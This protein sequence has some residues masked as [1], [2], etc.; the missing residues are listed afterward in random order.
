MV[1][2]FINTP[3]PMMKVRVITF[4]DSYERTLKHLQKMG[5]LHVE[6]AKELEPIDR[7]AIERDRNR[8]RK[9]LTF[10]H[11]ILTYLAGDRTVFLHETSASR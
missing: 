8:V 6:K 3:E 2:I 7:E 1:P 9:A 10:I 5:V 4:K 11:D